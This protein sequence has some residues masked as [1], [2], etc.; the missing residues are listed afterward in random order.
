MDD[1]F[2]LQNYKKDI[3]CL[4][5]LP[6]SSVSVKTD[7]EYA[8]VF[9]NSDTVAVGVFIENLTDDTEFTAEKNFFLL[10]P[11][12]TR[13]IKVNKRENLSVRGMNF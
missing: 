3:G 8:V 13:K 2:Y 4:N 12:E 7:K 1:T 10:M 11:Y 5:R 6:K 9:N